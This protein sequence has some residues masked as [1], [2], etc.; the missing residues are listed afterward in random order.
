MAQGGKAVRKVYYTAACSI[1]GTKSTID[2]IPWIKVGE[3]KNK[4]QGLKGCPVCYR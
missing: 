4:R 1:H 3:P 2:V